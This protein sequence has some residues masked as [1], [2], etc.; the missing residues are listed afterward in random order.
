[1]L[2]LGALVRLV[3]AL[4]FTLISF[5]SF[6]LFF[7]SFRFLKVYAE[8]SDGDDLGTETV[9][10]TSLTG[11]QP[12]QFLS[13]LHADDEAY[14]SREAGAQYRRSGQQRTFYKET[15]DRPQELKYPTQHSV[16]DLKPALVSRVSFNVSHSTKH[17][18]THGHEC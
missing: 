13:G 10:F 2:A 15:R 4:V 16:P 17:A 1:M 6:F 9:P 5:F 7:F 3:F 18:Y 8:D 12:V 11:Y 14:E